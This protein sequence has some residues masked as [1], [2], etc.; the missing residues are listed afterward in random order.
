MT[1]P[2]TLQRVSANASTIRYHV[3]QGSDTVGSINVRPSDEASLLANWLLTKIAPEALR[4][5]ANGGANYRKHKA[6][7]SPGG[8]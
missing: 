7:A 5:L 4:T 8:N 3:K 1:T 6:K 2:F